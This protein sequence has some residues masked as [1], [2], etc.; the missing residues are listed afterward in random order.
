M[1]VIRSA[2]EKQEMEHW[3]QSSQEKAQ[4]LLSHAEAL[5]G[6]VFTSPEAYS[7]FLDLT[8]RLHHY[9]ACNL[10]LIWEAYPS[11]KYLAVYNV[12][13]KMLPPGA[14][15]LKE[16]SKGKG[17]DVIAPFTVGAREQSCL[18]WYSRTVFD[19]SQTT[20]PLSPPSFDPAYIP[21]DEHEYFLLDAI[22]M[23]LRMKFGRTVIVQPGTQLMQ[24]IGLY[25]KITEEYVTVR[26]DLPH[27]EILKW[28]TEALSQLTVEGSS[29]SPA[30]TQLMRDSIRYCLFQIWGLGG[31]VRPP[32]S[33]VQLQSVAGEEITFLHFLRDSVR[34][35]NNL[36][37]GCYGAKRKEDADSED[38]EED[39]YPGLF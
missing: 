39:D 6:R 5:S 26:N 17:I 31:F 28:L 10:L 12:W 11:A 3:A 7:S 32:V 13:K 35:L 27:Q 36:V 15:I 18:V 29:L 4:R 16:E 33:T 1:A 2:M 8:S 20:L 25:G 30:S 9:D 24:D 14:Q 23:V 21:D 37:C 22:Q 38:L 34:N 19:V